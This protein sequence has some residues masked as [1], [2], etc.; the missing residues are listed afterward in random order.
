MF[1]RLGFRCLGVALVFRICGLGLKSFWVWKFWDRRANALPLS[2]KTLLMLALKGFNDGDVP[3][4]RPVECPSKTWAK[5]LRQMV[6]KG[7][8]R[9]AWAK[10][11]AKQRVLA[12][13][14]AWTKGLGRGIGQKAWAKGV[15]EGLA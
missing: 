2:Q 7:L 14:R 4:K 6:W 3:H 8:Q 12:K 9:K 1:Q 5:R 15:G 13:Q 10:G 11:L